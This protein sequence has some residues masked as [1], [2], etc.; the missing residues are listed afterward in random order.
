M[1]FLALDT[2]TPRCPIVP[3]KSRGSVENPAASETEKC[4]DLQSGDLQDIVY[5]KRQ[6]YS[7]HII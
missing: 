2:L 7:Y 4:G 1:P 3:V 5:M 6:A